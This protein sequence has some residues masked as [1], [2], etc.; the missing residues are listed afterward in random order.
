MATFG[1]AAAKMNAD[2]AED[3]ADAAEEAMQMYIDQLNA[4]GDMMAGVADEYIAFNKNLMDD[5]DPYALEE[6]FN[7]LYEGVIPPMER[8][9][10]ENV[11]AGIQQAYSGGLT[12]SFG[13]APS[14]AQLEAEANARRGLSETKSGLRY[15]ERNN[16]IDRNFQTFDRRMQAGDKRLEAGKL[17]PMMRAGIASD[18][19]NARSN[20]IGAGLAAGQ[21]KA[22][23]MSSA[24]NE[25]SGTNLINSFMSA[26][27]S[28]MGARQQ[29]GATAA[30]K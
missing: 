26:R 4:A 10:D 20:S 3:A 22:Q 16:A 7:S 24:G 1:I 25:F 11:M 12:G 28:I 23:I 19:Y 9:F 14:G 27:S 13:G 17:E 18:S 5:F 8:D 30:A 2:A 6:A 21:A 29:G 15:Q